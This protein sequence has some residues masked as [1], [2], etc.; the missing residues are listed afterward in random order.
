MVSCFCLLLLCIIIIIIIV[1]IIIIIIT[2]MQFC[3]LV[4]GL[5]DSLEMAAG[6]ILFSMSVAQTHMYM[7]GLRSRVIQYLP[8]GNSMSY[9]PFEVYIRKQH[10]SPI[11]E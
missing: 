7:L 2:M 5:A 8:V 9:R 4:R 3:C 10:V 6:V 11:T 1:I